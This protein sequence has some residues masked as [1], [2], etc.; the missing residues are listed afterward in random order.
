MI[1]A[2]IVIL[3][4]GMMMAVVLVLVRWVFDNN[5]STVCGGGCDSC[6]GN[7]VHSGCFNCGLS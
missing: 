6:A 1:R 3:V 4:E 7:S 2:V 5:C